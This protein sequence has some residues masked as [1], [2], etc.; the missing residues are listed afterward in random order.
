[1]ACWLTSLLLDRTV[2][3]Y[4]KRTAVFY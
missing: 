1:M 2:P 3:V 4:V